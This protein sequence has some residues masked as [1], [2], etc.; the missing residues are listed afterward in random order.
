MAASP[1]GKTVADT[2]INHQVYKVFPNDLNSNRTVFG[3]LVMAHLDRIASV[4][5][6]RHSECICVTASV[7][8]LHFL[9][10]AMEGEILIYQASVNR[11]WNTS[12]EIGVRV[13]AENALKG[14]ERHIVSAY[15][16]FVAINSDGKPQQVPAVIPETAI[17]KRRYADAEV[18]REVRKRETMLRKQR[19]ADD[20]LDLG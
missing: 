4:V 14:E 19:H 1:Q 20:P 15:F 3:G 18:R 9:A 11:A 6:D 10:P 17:Q 2:A 8:A 7:D 12:M 5:A 16:T 13:S